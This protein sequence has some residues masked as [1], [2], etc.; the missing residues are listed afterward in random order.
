[1]E[2]EIIE[3]LVREILAESLTLNLNGVTL[4]ARLVDDLE[5]GSLELI[6]ALMNVEE[7]FS[8]EISDEEVEEIVTVSDLISIVKEKKDG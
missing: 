5:A 2:D 8:I 7:E 3:I 1:M 6:E 4:D